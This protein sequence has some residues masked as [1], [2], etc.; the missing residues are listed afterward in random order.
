MNARDLTLPNVVVPYGYRSMPV[1]QL[2]ASA[3]GVCN[4]IWLVRRS[5]PECVAMERMLRRVGEVVELD[6]LGPTQSA[7]ALA[8]FRPSG[9]VAFR[10]DDLMF[11]AELARRLRLPFHR[12]EV[13]RNLVDKCTQRR[14]LAAGGLA[15][16]RCW[17]IPARRDRWFISTLLGDATFPAVLKPRR[18]SGSRHTFLIE[19][20]H[21]LIETLE[22]L[23]REPGALE[24]MVLEEYLPSAPDAQRAPFADYVSVESM[25]DADGIH[26]M[27][28]TGRLHQAETFRETGFFIPSTLDDASTPAVLET[29]SAALRAPGVEFGCVHTEI[30]LTPDGPRVLEVNGRLGGGVAEMLTAAAGIDPVRLHLRQAI[31]ERVA[32]EGPFDCERIGYRLFHQP[33]LSAERVLGVEGL[34]EIGATPGVTSVGL[35]LSPGD[36]VDGRDGTRSF[37]FSV[38]GTCATHAE[39]LEANWRIYEL[40]HVAYLHRSDEPMEASGR[41]A[42]VGQ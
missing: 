25:L 38:V 18:G 16:P 35:H 31:G 14:A 11:V 27:A 12:P 26:H 8:P 3:E 41:L 1:L 23:E 29:A 32:P 34:G 5:D 15:V 36:P 30:K 4:L 13:A 9:I 21:E 28:V 10:D 37:V 7:E 24:D 6:G 40:A 2:A 19:S 17:E 22:W 20:S 42:L 39:V 33:P